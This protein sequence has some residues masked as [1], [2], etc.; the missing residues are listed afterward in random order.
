MFSTGD[1]M[2]KKFP[3]FNVIFHEI[4]SLFPHVFFFLSFYDR[5]TTSI[6]DPNLDQTYTA[7]RW[8]QNKPTSFSN[9]FCRARRRWCYSS[10]FVFPSRQSVSS[11]GPSFARP[12]FCGF[13]GQIALSRWW[14]NEPRS[15]EKAIKMVRKQENFIQGMMIAWCIDFARVIALLLG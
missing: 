7:S 11:A 6:D 14:R 15:K 1:R 12:G 9:P 10:A 5:S 13:C 4:L 3:L 2:C 8:R